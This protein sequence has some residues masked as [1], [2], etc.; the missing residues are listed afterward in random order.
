MRAD[1]ATGTITIAGSEVPYTD[2]SV[3]QAE[4]RFYPEN[5]R[6]YSIV[7]T[8]E[9][10]PTQSHIEEV[11]TQKDH[12]KQLIQSIEANGGLIDPLLVRDGDYLVLEGNS[13]LAAYRVLAQRDPIRWARVKVRLLPRDLSERDIFSLLCQYHVI[14]RTDWA[15]YEQAG[16]LW[17]RHRNGMSTGQLAKEMGGLSAKRINHLIQVYDFMATHNDRNVQHWSYYDEY[18][19]ARTIQRRRQQFSEMDAVVVAAVQSGTIPRAEDI[20]DKLKVVAGVPG[21]TGATLARRFLDDPRALDECFERASRR[22]SATYVI[23]TLERFRRFLGDPETKR[24][25]RNL[26]DSESRDRVEYELEKIK[27]TSASL[28]RDLKRAGVQRNPTRGS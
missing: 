5:P 22:D 25:I 7:N 11:L 14:G 9:E 21:K 23:K 10:E 4:L 16:I 2:C 15:P 8:S 27:S 19:K 26:P 18:L 6:I 17:R 24:D 13:R 1:G 20:R 3:L 12:V 28:V